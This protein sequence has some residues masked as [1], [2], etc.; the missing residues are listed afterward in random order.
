MLRKKGRGT[1]WGDLDSARLRA[2]KFLHP[3]PECDWWFADPPRMR[4]S[5]WKYGC[6]VLYPDMSHDCPLLFSN[7]ENGDSQSLGAN[8]KTPHMEM[9][10]EKAV[11]QDFVFPRANLNSP[12]CGLHMFRISKNC[13]ILHFPILQATFWLEV[14]S[15]E[16]NEAS[17]LLG[18]HSICQYRCSGNSS[19]WI[20][21]FQL[22][23]LLTECSLGLEQFYFHS[24]LEG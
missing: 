24:S 21:C 7:Y 18:G 23:T 5:L 3:V 19:L 4:L 15:P 16:W 20:Q 2:F 1:V 14:A 22:T 6:Q 12:M 9:S 13:F 8:G 17:R 10:L 11:R